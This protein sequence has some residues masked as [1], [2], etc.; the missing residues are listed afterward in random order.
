[1]PRFPL[2]S[3]LVGE[4][5]ALDRAVSA[6]IADTP[7]PALDGAMTWASNAAN[8]SKLWVTAA[9]AL[10]ATGRQGRRGAVRGLV[11]VGISSLTINAVVKV[12]LPR[13]RPERSGTGK[14]DHVRMPTS[15]SFPS[16][17]SASAF[18]FATAASTQL[19]QASLPL[20]GLATI[21]GYS[22][23]HTGVHY[24]SD[25]LTGAVL[26]SAIGTVVPIIFARRPHSR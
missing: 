2:P 25:V 6:A 24:P 10:A 17:H 23:V 9:A 7:T 3:Q 15:S 1:L 14:G 13:R 18:A 22:R 16:G 11:A 19:P 26:G 20:Y 12:L 8:H 4:V 5:D 21:V